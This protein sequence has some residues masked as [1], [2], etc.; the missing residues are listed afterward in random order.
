M[1]ISDG[2]DKSW[3]HPWTTEEMRKKRREWSLAADAGLLKHLQQFSENVVSRANK[4]EEAL[5]AFTSQLNEAAILIDNVTNTSLALA[6]TQF[7]ESRVQED[8]IEI[9]KKVET[10]VQSKDEDL[11]TADLIA[12]VSESIKQGLS[13]MDEK[14]KKMEFVDSDSEEEDDDKV[15][16]SVVLG[17]NNPYQN[18]PLPYVIGSEKW[19]N[20]NK[21]GLESSS[22][23]ESEQVDEDE[24]E[25]DDDRAVFREYNIDTAPKTNIAGLSPSL[26]GSDYS[27]RSDITYMDNEKLD[28]ISQNNVHSGSESITPNDNGSKVPLANNS[29]PNFAEELAKRLGTVRQA[30]KPTIVDERSEASINRFK[31]DL[32]TPEVDENIVNDK[33]RS[34]NSGN[35]FLNDKPSENLWKE[36]PIEPY[37]NNIIPASIDVPPPISTVSVNPKSEIDDLFA[38][39]DS[40]DSDNIF[41]SKNT[42][43]T[44]T[45]NKH[46]NS[47]NHSEITESAQKKYLSTVTPA[48]TSQR[49]TSTPETNINNNNLFS[50]DEDD[51]DLFGPSKN[52]PPNK[53]KPAGVS[54][55]GNIL[56]SSIESKLANKISRIQSSESSGSDI[57]GNFDDSQVSVDDNSRNT[58]SNNNNINNQSSIMARNNAGNLTGHIESSTSSGIS[59]RPSSINNTGG[60]SSD[61]D[62][63]PLMTSSR[64]KS[65]EIYRERV[66]SDSLFTARTRNPVNATISN[67]TSSQPQEEPIENTSS[68]RQD[69]VF[70]NEDLFGPPPLPKANSK[71]VK[72]KVQSL[73]DDSDSGDELFS[74]TSSGSRSQKSTDFLTTVSQHPDKSKFAQQRGLFD[75]NIDIF[76]S[77]DSPDVDI[78][79]IASKSAKQT[80]SFPGRKFPDSSEDGL[81]SSNVQLAIPNNNNVEK[82]QSVAPKKISLFDDGEDIDDG[83]LFSVKPLRNEA[84]VNVFSNDD[85]SDLFSVKNVTD[86]KQPNV[87]I[88]VDAVASG[89]GDVDEDMSARRTER[90]GSDI[91][92]GNG[93]FSTT[94]G[95]HGLVFEDDDYDDLFSSKSARGSKQD[96]KSASEVKDDGM[97]GEA[98]AEDTETS[99]DSKI[100]MDNPETSDVPVATSS[101]TEQESE[102]DV[103][104]VISKEVNPSENV[105]SKKSPPKS[106]NIQRTT[107]SPPSEESKKVKVTVKCSGKIKNLVGKMG[108]LKILSPM[109][110]PPLWRKSEEKTDEEDSAADR[111]SD[112]GGCMSTQGHSSPPSISEDSTAQKHSLQSTIS[113]ESNVESAISF[114]EPAQVETLSIAASKTRVRIQAKR[115]P[116]SRHARKT[117]LRHSGIDFDT[118]DA[119]GNNSQNENYDNRS[120]TGHNKESSSSTNVN[121]PH[122]TVTSSDRLAPSATD[123]VHRLA[124]PN[125]SLIADDKSELGS[126]SKES[127]MS[128]NKNTLLSPSTDEEDLFDVP[129]DLPE[130]PQKEDTLFGRAPI[131]SPVD[132]VF[133][134]KAPTNFKPLKDTHI[135][136]IDNTDTASEKGTSSDKNSKLST[137][138]ESNTDSNIN[139]TDSCKKEYMLDNDKS[140]DEPT[141]MTDPL[142]DS[143]HDPLKDPSQLFAFVTKT[144]S[145]EKGK[146]LLFSEDDSLFSSGVKR[147]PEE[148]TAKKKML[149]LF[150]DDTEGDLFSASLSKPVKKPLKDTKISLF[151]D[152]G[153]DDEDDNLFGS[154]VKKS[155][156]KS[157]TEN[158]HSVQQPRKKIS[159][160][161][162]SDDAN[163]FF[164]QSEV[165]QKSD[166]GSV[167]EKSNKNEF[168]S[169]TQPVKTSHIMDIFA[170]QSS[171]EDDIFATKSIP[172]KAG[173]PKSLFLSDDD[174]DD[175]NIFGKKSSTSEPRVKQTEIRST[176]KKSVTRDLKKTAENISEDPLSILQDD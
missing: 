9:E 6:N 94:T 79:G 144:P 51:G 24:S 54:I 122:T 64:L 88:R 152:D 25:S 111:D 135:K 98:S 121:I 130:D 16:L 72:T 69:D 33:P 108:D 65:E 30:Q 80:N 32:L 3:D 28:V 29:A 174:D 92:S 43:K 31:D 22:S 85:K 46:T 155:S 49:V 10:S 101:K 11:A 105:E 117:A 20:S 143:S 58:I 73:F 132:R 70:E 47:N 173:T 53:I 123:N 142:R 40:E 114:D 83:D 166:S 164:D 93:L 78:F 172:K 119:S 107:S 38:D 63:Q 86:E 71:P 145:P 127:S 21:I 68:I 1:D 19:N 18:R 159:L 126:I 89:I 95:S 175:G 140:K 77:K 106:L 60:S 102:Q 137:S 136:K 109:D 129:P 120:S 15:V 150:A 97:F 39:A 44:I 23:S 82:Q 37:K 75:E 157:D 74:T 110:T 128:A 165:T 91:L 112:D 148:Q 34:I 55:L 61:V 168:P 134:E 87:K 154:I 133:L 7:I 139:I 35:T 76:G 26:V 103:G 141:E 36:K 167:Q 59:I 163:L 8:D 169:S 99:I 113:G 2:M 147:P 52:Q 146:S 84:K 138:T 13:I 170:D 161:D 160:F 171:G 57:P 125:M 4:T 27:K 115:R 42:V 12:S 66:V 158:K 131:L 156:V 5:D 56:S 50:D 100:F 151:D 41:S 104:Q 81:F 17:P 14:Y 90:K 67:S 149:D 62:F 124:D 153:Q 118:V 48:V 116:Q 45:K 96:E 176:I 162:D